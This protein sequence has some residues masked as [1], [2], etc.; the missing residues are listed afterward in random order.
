[1]TSTKTTRTTSG[2]HVSNHLG[3][4]DFAGVFVIAKLGIPD[5][6]KTGPKTAAELA[7]ATDTHAE[8]LFRVLRAMVSVGYLPPTVRTVFQIPLYPKPL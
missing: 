5:I 6:L 3:L 7:S 1:M 4:L 2:R 8:S